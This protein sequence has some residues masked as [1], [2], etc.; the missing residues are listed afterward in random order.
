MLCLLPYCISSG[1]TL[2]MLQFYFSVFRS[3]FMMPQIHHWLLWKLTFTSMLKAN[4][5]LKFF[6]VSSDTPILAIKHQNGVL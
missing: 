1:S 2:L 3:F 6:S 4:G 5:F